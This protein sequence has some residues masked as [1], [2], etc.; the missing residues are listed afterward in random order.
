MPRDD[1]SA[2][3]SLRAVTLGRAFAWQTRQEGF[4]YLAAALVPF[5]IAITLTGIL[6]TLTGGRGINGAAS[7]AALGARYGAHS[8]A[9]AVGLLL[10]FTPGLVALLASIA[11]IRT[12]RGLVGA[13][14]GRGDVEALL[15][16]PY[17][18]GVI[19]AALLGYT[20][21]VATAFWAAMSL[22]GAIAIAIVAAASA[23]TVTLPVSY[24]TMALLL[25]LLAV[26]ASAA[27]SVLVN[28]LFP[29]LTLP[30]AALA[31]AGGNVGSSIGTLPAL[32]VFL[33][34]AFGVSSPGPAAIMVVAGGIVV[35][36]IVGS[37]AGVARGFRA[38][39]VL[40][41]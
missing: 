3:R 20:M 36:I 39:N 17:T 37:V 9:V 1:R 11:V 7:A 21:V 30:G 22:M 10:I 25:P 34:I 40:E 8:N 29:K 26:W 14:V 27:L 41:S 18:P 24:L 23:G 35:L 5:A 33:T 19:A 6:P 15:S 31:V 16:A 13:E 2:R 32:G 4:R 28:L 38:E 12:T